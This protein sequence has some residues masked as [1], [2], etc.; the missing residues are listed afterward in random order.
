MITHQC[1]AC[2]KTEDITGNSDEFE[3]AGRLNL[4]GRLCKEHIKVY[5]ELH[6]AIESKH[7]A[8]QRSS[9]EYLR[10]NM[11]TEV[12]KKCGIEPHDQEWKVGPTPEAIRQMHLDKAKSLWPD[13]IGVMTLH[14]RLRHWFDTAMGGHANKTQKA[15]HDL[16][17]DIILRLEEPDGE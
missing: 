8:T 5:Q 17:T 4:K 9:L 2:G 14:D 13:D 3:Y 15:L 1:E 10:E 6:G 16:L 12:R 11:V 7:L